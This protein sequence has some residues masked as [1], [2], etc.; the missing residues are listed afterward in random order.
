MQ[1]LQPQLQ[2]QLSEYIRLFVNDICQG[3]IACQS[4]KK[5]LK[6]FAQ[7]QQQQFGLLCKF[8]RIQT[9]QQIYATVEPKL[10]FCCI[11]NT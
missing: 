3:L 8:I 1:Q 4:L 5:I 6:P 11:K 2:Y 7:V 9:S 10:I